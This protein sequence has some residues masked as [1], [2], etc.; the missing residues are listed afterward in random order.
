[1][2]RTLECH[3]DPNHHHAH[4]TSR[5]EWLGN[6]CKVFVGFIELVED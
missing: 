4:L 1:M 6:P 5:D 3:R 2:S